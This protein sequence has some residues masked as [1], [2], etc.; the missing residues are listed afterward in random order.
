M[1]PINSQLYI[2]KKS[3]GSENSNGV[4]NLYNNIFGGGVFTGQI[5][6]LQLCILTYPITCNSHMIGNSIITLTIF[7]LSIQHVHCNIHS[8]YCIVGMARIHSLNLFHQKFCRNKFPNFP[9][10]KLC[11]GNNQYK[12]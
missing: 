11:Y 1:L 6:T 5:I 4:I 2:D 8:T 3:T 9:A 7:P 10:T 12:L